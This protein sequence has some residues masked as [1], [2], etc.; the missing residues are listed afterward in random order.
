MSRWETLV[1]RLSPPGRGEQPGTTPDDVDAPV[2]VDEYDGLT[3]LRPTEQAVPGPSEVAELARTLGAEPGQTVATVVVGVDGPVPPAL[4]SRLG[5]V[6]DSLR[7][8]GTTTVRLVVSGAGSGD[9]DRPALAQR[10]ADAWGMGVIAPD[11]TAVLVPGGSLF[12]PDAP[13]PSGGWRLFQPGT[14]STPLGARHPAPGWQTALA[15]LPDRTASGSEVWPIPAGVLLQ[16]SGTRPPAPGALCYAVPV[17]VGR[18]TVLVGVPGAGALVSVDDLAALLAALPPSVR[19]Q[20]RL[21][22]GAEGDLLPTAQQVTDALGIEVEVLTGP[23]LAAP[24]TAQ[25]GE[26]VAPG[27][28]LVDGTGRPTWRPYVEA[29]VCRPAA[30]G[31][32]ADGAGPRLVRWRLPVPDG[33]PQE[34]GVVRVSERWQV[35]VSRSG[36]ALG[37][38]GQRLPLAERPVRAD[39]LAVEIGPSD[40]PLDE[41]CWSAL[42]HVLDYLDAGAREYAVIHA[43]GRSAEECRMLRRLATRHEVRMLWPQTAGADPDALPEPVTEQ[44]AATP[45]PEPTAADGFSL[46]HDRIG[47]IVQ[48]AN[49]SRYEDATA[50]ATSLERE[51]S[52]AHGQ[53]H[54][55][56]LQIRQIRAHVMR[57]SGHSALA[58]DLYRRVAVSLLV[59]AGL[60]SVDAEQAAANADACWRD[61]GDIALALRIAPSIIALREKVPGPDGRLL[62][63]AERYRA[64]L[65][66]AQAL[67]SATETP[68][69]VP[70]PLASPV[71]AAQGVRRPDTQRELVTAAP[72]RPSKTTGALSVDESTVGR[73]SDAAAPTSR[74]AV[75]GG[76]R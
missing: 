26:A 57:L 40:Q 54:P 38:V 10:I 24:S 5:D 1:T 30:S 66:A 71:T 45:R 21:A 28:V 67:P 20:V 18:P 3:L 17:D 64:Q 35:T 63:A 37:T 74:S 65:G 2:L 36:L 61:I 9:A 72:A 52:V 14:E 23:P 73:P 60:D 68:S 59:T 41:S 19:A 31:D 13:E 34:A 47:R 46:Y 53:E 75:A 7:D 58:A 6:L 55:T 27:P 49:A 15:A 33:E 12:V 8:N 51:A 44:P 29:V 70:V 62:K 16:P 76:S 25:S 48:A 42:S 32:D 11:G 22:P 50:L 43:P 69:A 56:S 4:W 39:Q